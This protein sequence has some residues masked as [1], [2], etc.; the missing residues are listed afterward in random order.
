M[1]AGFMHEYRML[2]NST[3]PQIE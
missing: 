2:D 1:K 3:L